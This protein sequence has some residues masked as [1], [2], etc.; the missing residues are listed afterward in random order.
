MPL[1]RACLLGCGVATGFGAVARSAGLKSG[2]TIAVVGC[3]GVGLAAINAAQ[4]LGAG[5]IFAVDTKPD[6]LQLAASLGASDLIDASQFDFAAQILEA[7][8]GGGVDHVVEA[9]GLE[10]TIEKGFASLAVGGLLTVAGA[11]HAEGSIRIPAI[12]MLLHE[13]RVQGSYMGGLRPALDIP[14]Y[15]ELYQD[16][17]LKLDQLLG[18]RLPLEQINAGFDA[19]RAG[20]LGRSV[21][22]FD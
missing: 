19:M 13:K 10:E 1:D 20:R 5:R 4:A 2:E 18:E 9:V 8:Q 16:G 15:V 17:R 11:T 21:I 7:T 3:G 6:K 22:A 12:P 14:R